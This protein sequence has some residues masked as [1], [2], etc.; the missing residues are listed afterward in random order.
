M[1]RISILLLLIILLKQSQNVVFGSNVFNLTVSYPSSTIFPSEFEDVSSTETHIFRLRV[2][3]NNRQISIRK[4]K[5][6]NNLLSAQNT[7]D[8][9]FSDVNNQIITAANIYVFPNYIAVIY[10]DAL[11]RSYRFLVKKSTLAFVSNTRLP[12]YYDGL[13]SKKFQIFFAKN[14][15]NE[16]KLYEGMEAA[17]PVY[18]N[19]MTSESYPMD[20][21]MACGQNKL[22]TLFQGANYIKIRQL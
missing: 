8:Y 11:L 1:T 16:I 15:N 13:Y 10:K 18:T 3:N 4:M 12:E 21:L 17:A 6:A 20:F 2:I 9:S 22:I 19:V 7:I 5:C 14:S